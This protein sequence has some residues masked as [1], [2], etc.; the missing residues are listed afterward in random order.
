L[1]PV[2]VDCPRKLRFAVTGS[3][4]ASTALG[5]VAS[6]CDDGEQS[7]VLRDDGLD[8]DETTGGDDESGTFGETIVI[9]PGPQLDVG[10]PPVA[11]E[12]EVTTPPPPP[13][14]NPGRAPDV[15]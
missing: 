3:L 8:R 11:P 15:R 2:A 5:V 10:A 7:V 13:V 6:G 14:V 1:Q 12:L 9:N 4:L